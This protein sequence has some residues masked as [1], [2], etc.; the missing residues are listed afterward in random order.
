M[1]VIKAIKP[2]PKRKNEDGTPILIDS[3]IDDLKKL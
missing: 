1:E 3:T 2:G